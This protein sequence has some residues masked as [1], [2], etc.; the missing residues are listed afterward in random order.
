MELDLSMAPAA[1]KR[2]NAESGL[3]LSMAPD[4]PAGGASPLDD[5]NLWPLAQ[6]TQGPLTRN[7]S[8]TLT[9]EDKLD[10]YISKYNSLNPDK[11]IS[12]ADIPDRSGFLGRV[13]ELGAG[14]SQAVVNRFP[15]DL[16]RIYE[17]GDVNQDESGFARRIIRDRQASTGERVLSRQVVQD[18]GLGK[19]LY[20][21][22][23]SVATSAA[24]GIGGSVIGG[25]AGSV[26]PGAG[27]V[28]GA[29]VGGGT[30]SGVAFYR[31]AK[32]QFLHE[33]LDWTQK[34]KEAQGQTLSN[35]EWAGI[36]KGLDDDAMK[37]GLWEA[38]PEALSQMFTVGL[39]K[40]GGKTPLAKIPGLSKISGAIADR[41]TSK[42]T[43]A[44]AKSGGVIAKGGLVLG[45]EVGEEEFT[46]GM[47]YFGQEAI[48]KKHGLRETD[49]SLTE[50]WNEQAG[51]VAV[52][53]IV[54]LGGMKAADKSLAA[55]GNR[56]TKKT[57]EG[58]PGASASD[59]AATDFG[60][61]VQAT[62]PGMPVQEVRPNV[63]EQA[64]QDLPSGE[65]VMPYTRDDAHEVL[66]R[67]F[68]EEQAE[69]GIALL[70]AAADAWAERE[71]STREAWYESKIAGILSPP[72]HETPQNS[73]E[74]SFR[75]D[76]Q[77]RDPQATGMD[78][79]ALREALRPL[80][81]SAVNALPLEV[82][83]SLEQLPEHLRRDADQGEGTPTAVFDPATKRV[84][85]LADA[86][87]TPAQAAALWMHEQGAHVGLRG[88]L[89]EQ[90]DPFLDR[91]AEH[92]GRE[93][94]AGI[95]AQHGIDLTT[96]DG[97]R[98]A[99]EEHLAGMAERI[100]AGEE[101]TQVE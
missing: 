90:L 99:A 75:P 12:K 8:P 87:D 88:L 10:A 43:L 58:A 65:D 52:G 44:L 31:L 42:I 55:L 6:N 22:P 27:N 20:E 76:E 5:V 51:P 4:S 94:L 39:L 36:A 97:L 53:S 95:A 29:I 63:E 96:E 82:V 37:F 23:Q 74:Y 11:P 70:D 93:A 69:P 14:L 91:V 86:I 33:M 2:Q 59:S 57:T 13:A 80:Q 47:T 19:S 17:G 67:H 85:L 25:M 84:Y 50:F 9:N 83:Q 38:G 24:V 77:E 92:V 48:R 98:H 89:G 54:Q 16:A 68:G 78:A 66:R 101:L 81:D 49:P 40:Y 61:T 7:T 21:G 15:E 41:A 35:E 26:V 18:E 100:R 56:L 62:P 46:E 60:A 34:A 73:P 3:D 32:N 79:Q 45:A 64:A 71:G 1:G 28:S 30:L 72:G